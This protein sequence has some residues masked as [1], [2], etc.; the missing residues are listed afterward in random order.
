M[1]DPQLAAFFITAGPTFVGILWALG[2]AV[3]NA[4]GPHP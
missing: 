1:T 2:N 4:L 3:G